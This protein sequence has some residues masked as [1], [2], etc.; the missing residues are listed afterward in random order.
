MMKIRSGE[1]A[2]ENNNQDQTYGH[3]VYENTEAQQD[4]L[5]QYDKTQNI[6]PQGALPPQYGQGGSGY[7]QQG[8]PPPY[9][10]PRYG[11]YPPQGGYYPPPPPANPYVNGNMQPKEGTAGYGIVSLVM[12]LLSVAGGMCLYVGGLPF[13][14]LGIIFGIVGMIVKGGKGFAIAGLIISAFMIVCGYIAWDFLL[15]GIG[16]DGLWDYLTS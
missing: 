7:P 4:G 10:D 8:A 12:S 15:A 3:G 16:Y 9:F 11:P 13:A 1:V 2:M 5:P 6:Q 14:A